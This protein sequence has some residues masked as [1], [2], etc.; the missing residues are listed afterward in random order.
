MFVVDKLLMAVNTTFAE[1]TDISRADEIF[2][3]RQPF[4]TREA[5]ELDGTATTAGTREVWDAKM[6]D[7]FL[8]FLL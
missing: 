5:A 3:S 6:L 7:F 2:T 1:K 8:F 4:K